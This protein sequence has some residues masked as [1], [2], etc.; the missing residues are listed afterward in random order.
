MRSLRRFLL[1]ILFSAAIT[2]PLAARA[3]SFDIT[4][5]FSGQVGSDLFNGVTF[6][7]LTATVRTHLAA[8]SL[9]NHTA[10]PTLLTLKL[11]T[12]GLYK[13]FVNGQANVAAGVS[14]VW[15]RTGTLASQPGY[16]G[17]T[18]AIRQLLVGTISVY[19]YAYTPLYNTA[20]YGSVTGSEVMRV[21]VPEPRLAIMMLIGSFGLFGY[22]A[23]SARSQESKRRIR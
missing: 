16:V 13:S 9:V 8:V 6:T 20:T 17:V 11:Y 1:I 22:I 15:L 14:A 19:Q 10:L 2:A 23:R 18:T 4:Y 12:P 3:L 5:Q 7:S 21:A